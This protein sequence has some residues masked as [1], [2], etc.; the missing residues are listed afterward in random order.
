MNVISKVALVVVEATVELDL[1]L[2][3]PPASAG[4]CEQRT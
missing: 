4:P 2:A 3:A 1:G